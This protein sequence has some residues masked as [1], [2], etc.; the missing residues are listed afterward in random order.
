VCLRFV[1]S[2]TAETLHVVL[3]E[4]TLVKLF[5]VIILN[6][7]NR[8]I[9]TTHNWKVMPK[10]FAAAHHEGLLRIMLAGN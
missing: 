10:M 1:S 8:N 3:G 4:L 9:N 2:P 5:Y 7:N 6:V